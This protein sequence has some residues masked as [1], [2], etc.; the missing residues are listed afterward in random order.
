MVHLFETGLQPILYITYLFSNQ[1]LILECLINCTLCNQYKH[2]NC[3]TTCIII[4]ITQ[5]EEIYDNITGFV[6]NPM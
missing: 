4:K 5:S 3:C 1:V 2:L 6:N